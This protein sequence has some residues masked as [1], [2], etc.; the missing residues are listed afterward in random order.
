MKELIP[1]VPGP[2]T[3]R[4]V[5]GRRAVGA[6]PSVWGTCSVSLHQH[7]FWEG[8]QPWGICQLFAPLLVV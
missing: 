6:G 4:E 5:V 1:L 3:L 7:D 2:L 8:Q